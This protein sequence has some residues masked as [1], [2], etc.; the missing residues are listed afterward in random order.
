MESSKCSTSVGHKNCS[1]CRIVEVRILLVYRQCTEWLEESST[2]LVGC[3][4]ECNKLV[5]C[6]LERST[7]SKEMCRCMLPHYGCYWK[8][9][10][11]CMLHH[12]N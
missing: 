9:L 12:S 8:L 1:M 2:C 3:K 4:W 5:M 11:L 7:Q 10:E 6:R